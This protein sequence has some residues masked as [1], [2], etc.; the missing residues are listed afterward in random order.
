MQTQSPF[1]KSSI[2]T[3]VMASV[4]VIYTARRLVSA[5]ALK[6]YVCVVSVIGLGALVWVQRVFENLSRVGVSGAAHF[7]VAAVL[8][9]NFL[10][11]LTLLVFT[12][13]AVSLARDMVRLAAASEQSFA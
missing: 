2:E 4:G 8:N 12:V 9:T 1:K 10:V 13:A 5:T 6:L 3:Q 7:M 11:Q